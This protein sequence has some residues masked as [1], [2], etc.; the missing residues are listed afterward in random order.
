[1]PVSKYL[2]S[3]SSERRAELE[4]HLLNRQSARCFICD[5]PIDLLLHQ[6][7]LDIDHIDPLV[8]QGRDAENNNVTT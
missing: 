7:Q 3:L 2:S 5:E 1:M 6:G 8:E 4:Q